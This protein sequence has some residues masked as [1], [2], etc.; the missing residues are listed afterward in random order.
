VHRDSLRGD[1]GIVDHLWIRVADLAAARDFYA[2]VAGHAGFRLKRGLPDRVQ[3]AGDTGTFSLVDGPPG[4]RPI[5]HPGYYG[6]FVRDP[7]GNVV[8]LVDHHR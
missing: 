7:D 5:S 2:R 6:A 8:E 1:G 3:L 4:E